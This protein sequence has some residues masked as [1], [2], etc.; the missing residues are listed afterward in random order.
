MIQFAKARGMIAYSDLVSRMKC[1]RLEP[2]DPRL[3]KL[4]SEIS[5]EEDKNGRGM[6]TAVVVHKSGD[7]EP[8]P[9]FFELAKSLGRKV[10]SPLDCWIKELHYVHAH[11]EK[12]K[13]KDK[14]V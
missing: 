3:F 13:E 10:T 4:L 12:E 11:W 9:G 14:T 2:S 5:S 7:M 8:G 1:I 6:L